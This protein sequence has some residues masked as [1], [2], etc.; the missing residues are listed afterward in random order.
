M[1]LLKEPWIPVRFF[2]GTKREVTLTELLSS[3]LIA[4]VDV[5]RG[6]FYCAL[7]VWLI[8]ILQ[9]FLHPQDQEGWNEGLFK[10]I[11]LKRLQD[12]INKYECA[13]NLE[14]NSSGIGFMQCPLN[15]ENLP[16]KDQIDPP[17][18]DTLLFGFPGKSTLDKNHDLFV[19]RDAVKTLCPTCATLSLITQ[20]RFA[21]QGGKGYRQALIGR[22]GAICLA[23]FDD[24]K[25]PLWKNLWLNVIYGASDIEEFEAE[26]LFVWIK[27]PNNLEDADENPISTYQDPRTLWLIPRVIRLNFKSSDPN[28]CRC[29]LC[30]KKTEII[31][32][33]YITKPGDLK[34][35]RGYKFPFSLYKPQIKGKKKNKKTSEEINSSD[36][37][38][39]TIQ[40]LYLT[41]G[42]LD[43][44][45][46]STVS[47]K[48]LFNAPK[49]VEQLTNVSGEFTFNLNYY[50]FLYLQGF[51]YF[52]SAWLNT[53]TIICNFKD[54]ALRELYL[55]ANHYLVTFICQLGQVLFAYLDDLNIKLTSSNNNKVYPAKYYIKYD[56]MKSLYD[57]LFDD[58]Q[59]L[60][61]ELIKLI[62]G[63]ITPQALYERLNKFY[64]SA[65]Q[66]IL[67]F[68]D[69]RVLEIK[70]VDFSLLCR[71]RNL[72]L[73][74]LFAIKPNTLDESCKENS[75]E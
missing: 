55:K 43:F 67:N 15:D 32:D 74:D 8:A 31:C 25:T 26:D 49:N 60:N 23:S 52:P 65:Q 38:I 34:Q 10:G 42:W 66:K 44:L 35:N 17:N 6:D 29:S 54:P 72:F 47:D 73:K 21:A 50:G 18:L 30:G 24:P 14:V 41:I 12:A 46:E 71:N 19:K 33:S 4:D 58:Y 2:D 40:D 57:L 68:Y 45:Q 64:K 63:A 28:N 75:N 11:D 48:T 16:E 53:K 9:T 22:D 37:T 61:Q 13:F 7:K 1:N 20:Q 36:Y 5:V 59:N 3:N 39:S 62:T 27:D 70:S 69:E 51:N 56:Y